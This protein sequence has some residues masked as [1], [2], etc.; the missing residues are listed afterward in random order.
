[1]N[2]ISAAL[3][4]AALVSS[5]S[6]AIVFVQPISGSYWYTKT[7]NYINLQSNN[8]EE[9]FATIRFSSC[10]QCFSLPVTTNTTIPI[11]LPRFIRRNNILNLYAISDQYNTAYTTVNVIDT[12]CATAGDSCY[13]KPAC[14]RRG[15][16][17]LYAESSAEAQQEANKA[18]SELVYIAYE[19]AEAK[20]LLSAQE[21]AVADLAA[22]LLA[23]EQSNSTA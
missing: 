20:T 14:G 13:D 8:P 11:V 21:Q 10:N 19:S 18:E 7:P 12:L 15:G 23:S 6:A 17:G 3:S 22:D 16:C 4:I 2:L 9:K 1:M 5:V